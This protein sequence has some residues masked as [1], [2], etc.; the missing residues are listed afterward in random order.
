MWQPSQEPVLASDRRDDTP[1]ELIASCV[2]TSVLE[3]EGAWFFQPLR[4]GENEW[5][6]GL[7]LKDVSDVTLDGS[8]AE[9]REVS[10]GGVFVKVPPDA[11]S[12]GE[13]IDCTRQGAVAKCKV[14]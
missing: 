5:F 10:G 6:A 12:T 1:D 3:R 13:G 9:V 7:L 14:L 4:A 2:G 11:G 8:P